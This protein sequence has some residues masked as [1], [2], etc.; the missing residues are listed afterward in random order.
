MNKI[1]QSI[2][3]Q[4]GAIL[5]IAVFVVSVITVIAARFAGDFQLSTARIKQSLIHTQLQQFAYSIE[6]FAGWVL[7][8]D[9][10]FDK[11][12]S[13]YNN[14][15]VNGSYDHLQENWAQHLQA[16]IESATVEA[17]LS[18]A[19]SRFN[20]NQL[21]GKPSPYK[22]QG[23]FS[24]RYTVAQQRFIR[25]L[26][27]Y[28]D[29]AIDVATA[30]QITQAVIDWL[31]SDSNEQPNGGAEENYYASLEQ[32]YKPAN[33]YFVSVT[34]L[35]QVKG[36]SADMYR[37]L[38]PLLIALPNKEGFNINTAPIELMRTLQQK[39]IET[40]LS[41]EDANL[42]ISSRPQDN[43]HEAYQSVNGFLASSEANQIFGTDA[44]QWPKVEGLR[45]G[46]EYFILT[47]MIH[48]LDY[49]YQLI[50]VIKRQSIDTGIV[51]K[52][53]RRT[54]EQL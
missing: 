48:L 26:Q 14:D 52:V 50:S 7:V 1:P 51:T 33:R 9:A 13:R 42:L 19:M 49:Q 29:D 24:E 17:T 35:K 16:P 53:L 30:Q 2:V 23:T 34:E 25:L 36:I 5:I 15:G 47:S 44:Q 3:K 10:E 18:D 41:D 38:S 4:Q 54:R 39:N 28:P 46:S 43:T 22:P 12:H 21:Q 37:Y 20:I 32:P 27:T 8:Q 31:D 11:S 45:T 40:P 6:S